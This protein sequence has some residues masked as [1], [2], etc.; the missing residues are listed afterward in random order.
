VLA[1]ESTDGLADAAA[2]WIAQP[3]PTWRVVIAAPATLHDTLTTLLTTVGIT[4]DRITLIADEQHNGPAHA[5]AHAAASGHSEHL[6]LM[7]SPAMGLTHDWLT[8]LI[9]YSQQPGIAAAGPVVLAPDGRI[10]HAGIAIPTGTPLH[11]LHGARP[12]AAQPVVYNVLAVSGVLATSRTT[13]QQLNGLHPDHHELTLIDYCLRATASQ[14]DNRIV[15]VPDTRLRTTGPD[16]TTNDLPALRRLHHTWTTTHH[17][18]PYYNPNYRTDRG[19]FIL[20]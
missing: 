20:A 14:S 2:S 5:L 10:Q 17:T 13:Y 15:I 9:G 8:R 19:D 4:P 3:H 16:P 7:H 18:D 1:V 12:A 6:L 11:L